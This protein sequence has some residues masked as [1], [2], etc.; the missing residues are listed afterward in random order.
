M[1]TGDVKM[2]KQYLIKELSYILDFEDDLSTGARRILRDCI[3]NIQESVTVELD[4]RDSLIGMDI[5]IDVSTGDDDSCN[6]V[7]ATVYDYVEG[8]PI[9]LLCNDVTANF[10]TTSSGEEVLIEHAQLHRLTK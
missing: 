10:V 7:F 6:R 3:K 4:I 9:T 8:Q 1:L 5:S 2:N